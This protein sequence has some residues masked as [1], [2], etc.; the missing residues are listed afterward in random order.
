MR[1][2]KALELRRKA[3]ELPAHDGLDRIGKLPSF[4]LIL[5]PEISNRHARG[6]AELQG[7]TLEQFLGGDDA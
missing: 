1:R 7:S 4:R 2:G 6:R 5:V 3:S